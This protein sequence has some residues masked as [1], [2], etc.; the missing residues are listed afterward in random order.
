M[1]HI[2]PRRDFLKSAAGAA[3]AAAATSAFTGTAARTAK[4]SGI[5]S[6]YKLRTFNYDGVRLLPSRWQE[7]YQHGRDFYFNV[8]NDDILQGFRA[9]A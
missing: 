9:D 5:D 1:T 7:Q 4:A 2:L 8:S 3:A 6:R